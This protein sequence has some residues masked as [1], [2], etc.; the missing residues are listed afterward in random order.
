MTGLGILL[1]YALVMLRLVQI[2]IIDH[3]RYESISRDIRKRFEIIEARRGDILD[4]RGNLLATTR[5]VIDLGVDPGAVGNEIDQT[6]VQQLAGMIG[7][8]VEEV[9][10]EMGKR[11]IRASDGSI[12]KVGWRDLAKGISEDEY[13][14][15]RALNIPGVYGNRRYLRVYPGG[16]LASHVIGFLNLEPVAVMGVERSMDFYLSGQ[17]GWRE[18]ERAGDRR[19][20]AHLRS[21]EVSPQAGLSVQ[22][23]IE[24][25]VQNLVEEEIRDLVEKYSP[26]S[27]SIIVSDPITGYVTA[28]ANYPSFD[29]NHY[30]SSSAAERRNRVLTDLYEPGSTFKV[31][32]AA[33]ALHEKIVT[34]ETVFDCS[35]PVATYRG[36]SVRL[37]SD[38]HPYGKLSVAEIVV[39][40]SNRGAAYLGMLLGEK[41]LHRYAG[42]F[43]FG[44]LTG[45]GLPPEEVGI[46]HPVRNWDGLTIT[47]M[48]MGHA[49]SAT[50]MQVHVAISA[51]AN[52]GRL[53]RPQIVERILD[54][55]GQTLI[56]F[57]PYERRQVVSAEAAGLATVFM[58]E[59]ASASGTAKNASLEG[60]S[61]GGKTG[62]TQ[63]LI[64]GVY[65][66]KHHVAS[67][68]GFIPASNP[69]FAITVVVTDPKVK[70][71]G[72]GG[73]VAAPAFRRIAEGLVQ[74]YQI[75]PDLRA[76]RNLLAD[77]FERSS[78]G[79]VN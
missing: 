74:Y 54:E 5:A 53:M 14:A 36:R 22:L 30:R 19:E 9:L 75:E 41:R 2:Q 28:L 23:T 71:V 24:A 13:D 45:I 77:L 66:K 70:G 1:G 50:P 38:H 55:N 69:R 68:A 31:I 59:V 39:K 79:E 42:E 25:P 57:E 33:A 3:P 46:L 29:L 20:L 6:K 52:R 10:E 47:R 34:P 48:P 61:V 15:I 4:A 64:D 21:R 7:R 49:I 16:S 51:V 78:R 26:E 65:S 73:Q 27:V 67:F 8:P 72:Y 32:T 43:G 62:T 56:R 18:S 76:D 63:M 40:S 35:F 60:F 11:T 58:T 12:R 44:E 37:P 17:R